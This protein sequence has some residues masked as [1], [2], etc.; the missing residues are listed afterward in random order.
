MSLIGNRGKTRGRQG[1]R[2]WVATNSLVSDLF[3]SEI[4]GTGSL[5]L[6]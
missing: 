1:G 4:P 5:V 3:D 6:Q 2:G